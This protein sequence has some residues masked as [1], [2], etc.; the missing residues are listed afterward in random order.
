MGAGPILTDRTRRP[1]LG[2]TGRAAKSV[3]GEAPAAAA[4]TPGQGGSGGNGGGGNGGGG[5]PGGPRGRA[6]PPMGPRCRMLPGERGLARGI[7]VR[8]ATAPSACFLLGGNALGPAL[9]QGQGGPVRIPSTACQ[10]IPSPAHRTGL[11]PRWHCTQRGPRQLVCDG[12]DP[13]THIAPAAGRAGNAHSVARDSCQ[14]RAAS[15][16][17]SARGG[18]ATSMLL[19]LQPA[20][21]EIRGRGRQSSGHGR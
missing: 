3:C 13:H 8:R 12:G 4:S 15:S 18:A 7:R 6:Y 9:R 20:G 2:A 1:R 14:P 21:H 10:V 5:S 19:Q 17:R 16:S 11:C